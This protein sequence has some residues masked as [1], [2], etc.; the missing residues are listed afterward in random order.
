MKKIL[1]L[2]FTIMLAFSVTTVNVSAAEINPGTEFTNIL[3]TYGAFRSDINNDGLADG[4]DIINSQNSSIEDNEQTI[5]SDGNNYSLGIKNTTVEIELN[6]VYYI[7]FDIETNAT[8]YTSSMRIYTPS[9]IV[10]GIYEIDSDGFQSD[11]FTIDETPTNEGFTI[12]IQEQALA[13]YTTSTYL[14]IK[15]VMLINLTAAYGAGLEPT[16]SEFEDQLK[17]SYFS[18]TV[19]ADQI[20]GFD[21]NTRVEHYLYEAPNIFEDFPNN[22]TMENVIRIAFF[23]P[24]MI[25][26]YL[27]IPLFNFVLGGSATGFIILTLLIL[28]FILR[29][30]I[31]FI[32]PDFH[33]FGKNSYHDGY[34]RSKSKD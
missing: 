11:T 2:I 16:A 12:T 10:N 23:I 24:L 19:Q 22:I 21:N 34:N 25:V 18:G 15:E 3:G 29:E 33:L 28:A 27:L 31:R 1:L 26:F 14:K 30:V 32:D 17:V 20:I 4:W 7:S 8:N 9:G 13:L 6:Q 5:F